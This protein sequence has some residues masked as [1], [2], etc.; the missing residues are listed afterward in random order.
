MKGAGTTVESVFLLIIMMGTSILVFAIILLS[1][2]EERRITL[3]EA[4]IIKVKSL[5]YMTNKS[6]AAT[7]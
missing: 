3:E 1:D 4:E 2:S 7:W 6:L 5:A